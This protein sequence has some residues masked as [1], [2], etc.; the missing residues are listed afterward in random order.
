M[1][2]DQAKI[3]YENVDRIDV[4]VTLKDGRACKS[5]ILMFGDEVRF[6]PDSALEV[7]KVQFKDLRDSIVEFVASA[8]E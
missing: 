2:E 3:F 8:K 4:L 6:N 7:L 5:S 1:T